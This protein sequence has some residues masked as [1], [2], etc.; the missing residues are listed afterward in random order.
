[1]YNLYIRSIV[2]HRSDP[3]SPVRSNDSLETTVIFF[4]L[5]DERDFDL[6]DNEMELKKIM[7]K[8]GLIVKLH[9]HF[10]F[11]L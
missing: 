8:L 10:F 4:L 11:S 1:M 2:R 5:R 7:N 3:V 9:V 6:C